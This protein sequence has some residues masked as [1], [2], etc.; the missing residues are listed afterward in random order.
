MFPDQASSPGPVHW[1]PGV[2]ATAPPGKSLRQDL[3][4]AVLRKNVFSEKPQ[5][6]L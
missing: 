3:Y 1:E 2:L 5:V 4:V 6:L